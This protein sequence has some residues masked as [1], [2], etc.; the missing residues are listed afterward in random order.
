M[1]PE[2]PGRQERLKHP[3]LPPPNER[4][5]PTPTAQLNAHLGEKTGDATPHNYGPYEALGVE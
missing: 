2:T 4:T 1:G 3:L 5:G